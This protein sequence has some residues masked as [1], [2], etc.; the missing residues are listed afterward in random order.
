MKLK[1]VRLQRDKIANFRCTV[2]E[3]KRLK[4]QANLYAEG[5]LSDYL[6]FCALNYKVT[7]KDLESNAQSKKMKGKR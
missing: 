1:T 7:K 6:R 3:Y 4:V 2:P 5:K